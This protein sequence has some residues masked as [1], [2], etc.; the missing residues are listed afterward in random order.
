MS[1]LRPTSKPTREG[2]LLIMAIAIVCAICIPLYQWASSSNEDAGA[3][4]RLTS[5]RLQQMLLGPEKIACY[6]AFVW[7]AF[8]LI[9]RGL[10]VRRQRH[11]FDLD[12]LP[13][14]EGTRI[15]PEDA[16]PLQRKLDQQTK[17]NP[18]ILANLIRLAL[19]RYG[20]TRSGADANEAVRAQADVEMGRMVSSMATVQY[21]A[22][23][24]PALGFL[25]TVRGLGMSMSDVD[26]ALGNLYYAFDTTLVAL[27]VS[28]PLMYFLHRVQRDEEGLVLDCQQYCLE[29]LVARLYD[30]EAVPAHSE[31]SL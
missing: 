18:F 16:R 22:W 9:S 25:G 4:F 1:I 29:H 7:G 20:I 10:E 8:I 12:L 6:C 15:L 11:A 17:G 28:L 13:T 2:P 19:N 26:R 3:S 21:L 5:E 24:I 23:A 27:L 30:P 31:S 14:E